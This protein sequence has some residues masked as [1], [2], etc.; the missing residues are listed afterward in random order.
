MQN[1]HT[2]QS[3][4]QSAVKDLTSRYSEVEAQG[5]SNI[6]VEHIAGTP[7]Y[8]IKESLAINIPNEHIKKISQAIEE[9]KEMRPTQ[10]VPRTTRFF[11]TPLTVNN[12]VLTPRSE[13]EELVS[14]IIEDNEKSSN[15]RILDIGTRSGIA[16]AIAKNLRKAHVFAWD[17]SEKA[18]SIASNNAKKNG[19]N[20]T[21][22][23]KDIFNTGNIQPDSFDVI[24]SSPLCIRPS[25]Q[26]N[27]K[28]DNLLLHKPH[29]AVFVPDESPLR[30]YIA[31]ADMAK[32]A[33]VESGKLYFE[34]NQILGDNVVE[35]LNQK[36]FNNSIIKK[37]SNSRN[38]VIRT[39]K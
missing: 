2:L 11:N 19:V 6:L 30:F 29:V 24:V 8:K 16:I 33:L 15:V 3:L 31:I 27:L 13:T 14:W 26:A 34:S 10:H 23:Q 22:E 4:Q 1:N 25:E 32:Q 5:V 39:Q 20:I 17:T 7:Q 12:D 18:L 36:G 9:L 37:S 35:M 28:P 21:F 38:R